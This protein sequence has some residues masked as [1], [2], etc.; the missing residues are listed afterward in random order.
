[1]SDYSDYVDYSNKLQHDLIQIGKAVEKAQH[2]RTPTIIQIEML[3]DQFLQ[4]VDK[5]DMKAMVEAS[6]E[7]VA[8]LVKWRV[9]VL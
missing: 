4:A 2:E 8:T 3:Y 7:F 5:D 9:E 6:K 1:M